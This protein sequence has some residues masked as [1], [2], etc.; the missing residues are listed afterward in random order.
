MDLLELLDSCLDV[1]ILSESSLFDGHANR[2]SYAL[3][4]AI[5]LLVSQ[6][7]MTNFYITLDA[8][9][10]VVGHLDAKRLFLRGKAMHVGML[11]HIVLKHQ[12]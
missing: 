4:M 1:S 10:I 12:S 3:Q 2:N 9:V 11:P 7:V 6:H 8:D 5:K